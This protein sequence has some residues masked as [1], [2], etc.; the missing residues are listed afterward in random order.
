MREA[1]EKGS[2]NSAIDTTYSNTTKPLKKKGKLRYI[3]SSM[4]RYPQRKHKAQTPTVPEGKK[5]K[6]G[7]IHFKPIPT[8]ATDYQQANN[9]R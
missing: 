6:Q 8:H 5:Q 2:M 9:Q 7:K 4:H 3:F 1:T